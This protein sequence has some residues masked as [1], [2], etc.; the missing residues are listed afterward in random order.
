MNSPGLV[1]VQHDIDHQG[2]LRSTL[3]ESLDK[4]EHAEVVCQVDGV[5]RSFLFPPPDPEALPY[6]GDVPAWMN[7]SDCEK[8]AAIIT[9]Q[10]HAAKHNNKE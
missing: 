3:T 9:Y 7:T 6:G 1:C 2:E 4:P 10:T 5:L 8:I